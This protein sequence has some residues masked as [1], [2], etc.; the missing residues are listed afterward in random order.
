MIYFSE[1]IALFEKYW[2]T[3]EHYEQELR[4]SLHVFSSNF[5]L[6]NYFYVIFLIN[7]I[8][9]RSRRY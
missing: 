7:Y 3:P 4:N 9:N 6:Y 8:L 1:L 2:K 5:F